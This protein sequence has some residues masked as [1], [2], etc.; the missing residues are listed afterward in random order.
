[1]SS[2]YKFMGYRTFYILI[3]T[4]LN[5]SDSALHNTVGMN[6]MLLDS[7]KALSVLNEKNKMT[8]IVVQRCV[9]PHFL[10]LFQFEACHYFLTF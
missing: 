7:A 8:N 10:L 3:N 1:M 9:C 4:R 2:G 6:F 5:D